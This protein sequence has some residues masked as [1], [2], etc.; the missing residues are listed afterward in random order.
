M[1]KLLKTNW[2]N[3]LIVLLITLAAI[4]MA[5][6]KKDNM[7]NANLQDKIDKEFSTS[8]ALTLSGLNIDY[9]N[10]PDEDKI[11]FY[12]QVIEGLGVAEK[13]IPLTSYKGNDDLSYALENVKLFLIKNYSSG[14]IFESDTQMEIYN[15]LNEIMINP[16][17]LKAVSE[18]YNFINSIE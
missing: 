1:G 16:R 10:T 3:I 11:Y 4:S 6:L 7:N 17:D 15:Y 12:S 14:F 9:I 8:L 5:S 2:R 13:L 18:L